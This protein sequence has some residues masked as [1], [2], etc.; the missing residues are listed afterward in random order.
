[1]LPEPATGGSNTR[2]PGFGTPQDLHH[3]PTIQT[4]G[5][6]DRRVRRGVNFLQG[7]LAYLQYTWY[8]Y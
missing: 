4:S 5:V 7:L 2:N 1:M 6:L 3:L 8:I